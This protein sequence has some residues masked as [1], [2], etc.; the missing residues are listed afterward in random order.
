MGTSQERQYRAV[1]LSD[2]AMALGPKSQQQ[3]AGG[4]KPRPYAAV[5]F[6][7]LERWLRIAWSRFFA[8]GLMW[9]KPR[10]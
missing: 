3:G 6:F 4:D 9:R 2:A 1:G 8:S 10:E 7:G 5:A